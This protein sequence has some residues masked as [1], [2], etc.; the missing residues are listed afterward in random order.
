VGRYLVESSGF[1]WAALSDP[2]PSEFATI[3][4]QFR[5]PAA[6]VRDS[7]QALTSPQ[8]E[9]HE[10]S[11][12]VVL[13]IVEHAMNGH[14]EPRVGHLCIFV[15]EKYVLSVRFGARQGFADLR[16]RVEREPELLQLGPG[17][18]LY[19]L[20]DTVVDRC[21]FPSLQ[22]LERELDR[23][24]ADIFNKRSL[25]SNIEALYNLKQKLV[26]LK[27]A[28]ESMIQVS[29]RLFGGRVPKIVAGLDDYFRDVNEHLAQID[30][31]IG[32][33]LDMLTTAVQVN[34][35]LINLSATEVTKK[36][37]AWGAMIAVPTM[38]GGIYGMNFENMPELK[39][40]F[41]YPMALAA[42]VVLDV[43][44]YVWFR[45]IQW[46]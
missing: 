30:R 33:V 3:A 15:A 42:M 34:L 6:L 32:G 10:D 12:L 18:V 29:G 1:V 26:T 20:M 43:A 17:Y 36:L 35:G 9:E 13:Q 23:I 41:G 14:D 4:A 22:V 7:Q 25:S 40:T 44:L 37:A 2:S 38:I 45:R 16:V 28:V 24:E 21:Y 46:L 5:L 39:W 27:H 8:L 11:L 31:S 19:A